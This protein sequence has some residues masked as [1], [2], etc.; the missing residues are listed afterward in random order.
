[1]LLMIYKREN[2]IG[3]TTA[4]RRFMIELEDTVLAM[5]IVFAGGDINK[6]GMA[7]YLNDNH[8]PYPYSRELLR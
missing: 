3:F 8:I 2:E 7:N 1:M 4:K 5:A 6:W